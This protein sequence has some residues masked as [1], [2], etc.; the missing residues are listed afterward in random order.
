[1]GEFLLAGSELFSFVDAVEDV[2]FVADGFGFL[3]GGEVVG[4]DEDALG[5]GTAAFHDEGEVVE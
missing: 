3:D 5:G 2:G 4:A 1:M